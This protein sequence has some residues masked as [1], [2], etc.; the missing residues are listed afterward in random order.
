MVIA[1]SAPE[2][3]LRQRI[4]SGKP[5][6]RYSERPLKQGPEPGKYLPRLL[7]WHWRNPPGK[8][9]YMLCASAYTAGDYA[10]F[11]LFKGRCYKWGYFPEFIEHADPERLL[12]DKRPASILWAGRFLDWKH[13]EVPVLTAR[14]L[15]EAGYDFTMKMAGSGELLERAAGLVRDWGLEGRV[16]L[17][18]PLPQEQL[19]REMEK[20]QIY[21]FT[22]DRNEGWG[23]VMNEAMNSGCAAV[24]SRA[25]G[26]VPFLLR[27]GENGLI[28]EDGDTEALFEKVRGLLDRP[29]KAA[30][31]G[32]RA[33]ETVAGQWNP[34]NAAERFLVLAEAVLRGEKQPRPFDEG[35]CSPAE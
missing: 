29:E 31:L 30:G 21:L 19:R 13:P 20:S 34:E 24:A 18:G 23:A 8:P 22:S 12:A 10:K 4:R 9:V 16:L 35:V 1:G 7:K 17:T 14:R 28:Y 11:G 33:Y 32:R 2:S 3:L 6:F 25:I 27:D 5:L 15:K 26:S